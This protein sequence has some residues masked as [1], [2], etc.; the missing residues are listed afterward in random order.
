MNN[1]D[2]SREDSAEKDALWQLLGKAEKNAVSPLFSR[3]VLREIRHS[4]PGVA[5]V[6]SL[7]RKRWQLAS[8]CALAAIL[9]G[10]GVFRL[11]PHKSPI[12]AV[13]QNSPSAN[14]VNKAGD[15]EVVAHLDELVAYEENSIWLEDSSN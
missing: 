3:N 10:A 2:N 15:A 6:F 8:A 4:K 14:D 13:T 12:S 11:A 9:L 5:G 1:F 7:L